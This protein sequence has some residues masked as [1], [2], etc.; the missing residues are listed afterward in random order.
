MM[1]YFIIAEALTN[2]IKQARTLHLTVARDSTTGRRASK[3]ATTE[4]GAREVDAL[5]LI[6]A[7]RHVILHARG[8]GVLELELPDGTYNVFAIEDGRITRIDDY[9][10]RDG[11]FAAAGLESG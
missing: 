10:E 9:A 2:I 6:G 4:S 11:A 1:A 7:E 3:S 5:E 8:A